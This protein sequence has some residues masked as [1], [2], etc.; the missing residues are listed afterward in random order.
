MFDRQERRPWGT[1][2]AHSLP[3]HAGSDSVRKV[4]APEAPYATLFSSIAAQRDRI[5]FFQ[6]VVFHAHSI[7]SHDWAQRADADPARNSPE[8]L[9]TTDGVQQFLDELAS[10]Y[11]VVCI[12][13]H[14]R[15]GYA[16]R[17]A[18]AAAERDDITV[19]P[20]MEIN[21]LPPP[22]Y[23][24]AI[25]VLAIFP[26]SLGEVAIERIF[27][28][29]DLAE[30][31]DRNGTEAVRFDDLVDLRNRIQGAGGLFV[32]AHIENQRRGHRARFRIDRAKTLALYA[33]EGELERD[34]ADEWQDP[35]RS[36]RCV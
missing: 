14:M 24:D 9:G 26:P 19:L 25:H 32:L 10:R 27:A 12:T 8:R 31:G 4:T 6:P 17:L 29:K 2:T 22:H 16:T 35:L 3:E 7:D 15:C 34:L 20:G 28:G 1:A 18:Q 36:V 33:D 30:P 11:S 5:A 21:C 23:S 13:D